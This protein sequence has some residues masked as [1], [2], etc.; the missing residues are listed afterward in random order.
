MSPNVFITIVFGGSVT[1]G[2]V[3]AAA[4]IL[5]SVRKERRIG[6]PSDERKDQLS[7]GPG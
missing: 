6:A 3:A 5:R 2:A 7:A 4:V 1:L